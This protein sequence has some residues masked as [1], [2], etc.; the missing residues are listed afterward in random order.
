MVNIV[1]YDEVKNELDYNLEYEESAV[2]LI[3]PNYK[4]K[5]FMDK[6]K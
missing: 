4:E 1:F 3:E 6:I 5:E 2:R